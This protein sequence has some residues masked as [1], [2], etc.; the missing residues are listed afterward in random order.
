MAS[1]QGLLAMTVVKSGHT[2]SP[3]GWTRF[4][5]AS[6]SGKSGEPTGRGN[7]GQLQRIVAADGGVDT[8]APYLTTQRLRS[9]E[10]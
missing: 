7:C 8:L 9:L 1:S 4:P 6:L 10:G 2:S 3:A 5:P